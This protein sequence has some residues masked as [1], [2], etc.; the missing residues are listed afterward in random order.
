M[1]K[2]DSACQITHAEQRNGGTDKDVSATTKQSSGTARGQEIK[3]RE[4][5]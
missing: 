4:T 3:A 5:T 1:A 2:L